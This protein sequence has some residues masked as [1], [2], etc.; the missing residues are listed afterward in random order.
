MKLFIA[1]V[2]LTATLF[3]ACSEPTP[4]T[5]PK[6][7]RPVTPSQITGTAGQ[8]VTGGVTVRVID[9]SDRGVA[10]AK[11]GF[12]I[13]G[14]D[15][16]VSE[17]LVVSDAE[18]LAHTEWTLGQTAGL[19]QLTVSV[20]GIDPD[21][22]TTFLATASPA[23]A[24]GLSISPRILRIQPTTGGGKLATSIVDQYG[25]AIAGPV[26]YTP[27]NTAIATV[28]STGDVTK[29]Q[30]G[31]T[32]VV[33][34]AQGFTDSAL[35]VVLSAS[36]PPCTGITAMASLAVGQVMTTGFVD[37]GACI[38]AA[39]GERD[40]AIIPFFDMPVPSAFTTFTAT[41]FGVK[42]TLTALGSVRP[43]EPIADANLQAAIEN[44]VAVDRR[45]RIAEQKLMATHAAGARQW[46]SEQQASAERRAT[47]AI[48]TPKIGD[49]F[50]LNVNDQEPCSSPIMRLGKVA[51]VTEHAVV[52]ADIAN[53]AN[54][55]TD[56]EFASM[57]ATFDTLAYPS[58]LA[59][60][61][62][63]TDIDNNG[64]VI[65]FFT[66]A[67]NDLGRGTLGFAYSRDLLPKVGPFGSCPGSNVGEILYLPVPDDV[68]TKSE[69]VTDMFATFGHE[70][71]H[72]INSGRRLYINLNA[73]PAEERWL[74]EGLSHIAEELL[75]YR[76]TNLAPRQNVGP[77]LLTAQY[78]Q[79]YL[80]FVR[81]NLA[82]YFRFTRFPDSQGPVGLDDNDDDLETRGATWSFLRYAADLRFGANEA[83]FWQ[84]L[85]N[86]NSTGMQN[87]Y[88]HVG[89]DTRA[90]M[91]NWAISNYV[92]DLVP[93]DPKYSQPSW[94]I[95]Q[96]PG[97][98]QPLTLQLAT[99]SVPSN[100]STT[101]TLRAL[102]S[103]ALRFAVPT[104]QEAYVTVTGL[105]GGPLSRNIQLAIVRTK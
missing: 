47:R 3:A 76:S 68:R 22:G 91:R 102:S 48:T 9:Y 32:Y 30:T 80:Y 61:G 37:N 40:Y 4:E 63:S 39:A 41:G 79:A 35:V 67:V 57:A 46:Y 5:P 16:S 51:A 86:A 38:P 42:T 11:V 58:D 23:A 75:F 81:Q 62:T 93:V 77:Q 56:A 78:Q 104:N 50:N 103:I 73:A 94:N 15:G 45:L 55:F 19:N 43:R 44:R 90:L 14:G 2:A 72:V 10:D 74:N 87:L 85:E 60:F 33:V 34:S 71:Q 17:R 88:E 12:S 64:R 27:R 8:P 29:G 21:S 95:R 66:H 24:A 84:S 13:I 28:T 83:A 96:V 36:D 99:Q 20:F 101:L 1:G 105:N 92:D 7:I 26:T 65:L 49:Q 82:R 25:N 59:N 18:G 54:G 6:A 52:I 98:Q 89:Q 69:V 97:F 31:S 100:P 53:P 70:F